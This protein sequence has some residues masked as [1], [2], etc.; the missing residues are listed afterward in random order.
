MVI[1]SHRLLPYF[2]ISLLWFAAIYLANH[3][4]LALMVDLKT[5]E[6]H[7]IEMLALH[8]EALQYSEFLGLLGSASVILVLLLP[9]VAIFL[10]IVDF[11][12]RQRR[13]VQ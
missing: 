8:F 2:C 4:G 10:A 9:V 5:G 6:K 7:C 3:S 12:R 1:K 13:K 11:R